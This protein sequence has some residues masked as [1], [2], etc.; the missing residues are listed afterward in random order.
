MDGLLAI[1]KPEGLT[2]FDVVA[3]IRNMVQEKHVGHGGT[4]DPLATGVL[5]IAIGK[6]TRILEYF[7]FHDK[8]YVVTMEL[9]KTSSTFD[10]EGI[11]QEQ[12]V[13]HIPDQHTIEQV[14][15]EFRGEIE[16]TPPSFSAIHV[17]GKRAYEL[18]RQ[19]VSFT[20]SP[21]TV[22]IH[23]IKIITYQFPF[24]TLFVHCSSGTYIRS[25]AHDIGKRLSTGA[26]VTR[27]QRTALGDLLLSDCVEWS[28]L[29]PKNIPSFL[30]PTEK[31]ISL[32]KMPSYTLPDTELKNFLDGKCI[33]GND[34]PP[35]SHMICIHHNRIIGIGKVDATG[36][37]LHPEKVLMARGNI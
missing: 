3:R 21:K 33:S 11:I 27:L 31:C 36:T 20:L 32:L 15:Q 13:Q 7:L 10:A 22:K 16:Q 28:S 29:T 26:M 34:L 24:L 4:L 18:A 1:H 23:Q 12:R 8:Q 35:T 19:Q 17:Q 14:L 9:G 30:L 25:L 2:S 6:M 5:L 37:Y